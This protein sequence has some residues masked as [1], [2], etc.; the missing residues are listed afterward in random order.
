MVIKAGRQVLL[1]LHKSAPTAG[2]S[3]KVTNLSLCE[4]SVEEE[5]IDESYKYDNYT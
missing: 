3:V 1:D 4:K 2:P 5:D